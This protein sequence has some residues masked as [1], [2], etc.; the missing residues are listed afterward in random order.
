MWRMKGKNVF[1]IIKVVFEIREKGLKD[2]NIY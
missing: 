2:K 1:E